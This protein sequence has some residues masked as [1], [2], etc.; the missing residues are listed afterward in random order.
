MNKEEAK[1]ILERNDFGSND[2]KDERRQYH[3]IYIRY[4]ILPEELVSIVTLLR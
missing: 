4:Q 2:W 3:K 1:K